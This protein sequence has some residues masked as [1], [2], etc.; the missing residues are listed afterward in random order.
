LPG[1]GREGASPG[2][3]AELDLA[4]QGLSEGALRAGAH[5]D[6]NVPDLASSFLLDSKASPE[7]FRLELPVAE[8]NLAYF[9]AAFLA[10]SV[11]SREC[12]GRAGQLHRV[13]DRDIVREQTRSRLHVFF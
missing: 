3:S 13:A 4:N 7:I 6:E 8:Q 10:S 1:G 2:F 5:L 9:V 12:L 11:K